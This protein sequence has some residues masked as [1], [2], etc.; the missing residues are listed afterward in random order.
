[1]NKL[2]KR[3]LDYKYLPNSIKIIIIIFINWTFQSFLYMD[4]AEK[5]YKIFLDIVFLIIFYIILINIF[6]IYLSI[7]I[8]FL[9][10][11]TINWIFNGHIFALLKT[12]G[13][14]QT[15]KT[16][17]LKYIENIKEKSS[18]TESIEMIAYFGSLSRGEIKKTSDLDIRVIRKNGFLNAFLCCLFINKERT[19]ALYNRFPLD[20]YSFSNINKV[21]MKEKPTII[22]RTEK[23]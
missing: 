7:I 2:Y 8:A 23:E 12:F 19:L 21:K 10:A 13:N 22:Y 11:H 20:I 4:L 1:M 5:T 6:D 17:F 9:I 15:D 16:D 14:I 18:Q 3:I